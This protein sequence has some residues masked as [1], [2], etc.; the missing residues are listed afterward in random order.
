MTFTNMFTEYRDFKISSDTLI[1]RVV[2]E[3]KNH[4]YI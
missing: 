3:E 2:T 4:G 1:Y